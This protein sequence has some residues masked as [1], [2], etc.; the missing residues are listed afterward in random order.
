MSGCYSN[1]V[2]AGTEPAAVRAALGRTTAFMTDVIDGGIVVFPE[3]E[4]A[5][6]AIGQNLSKRLGCAC[7][8]M[9]VFEDGIFEYHLFVSGAPRDSYLSMSLSDYTGETPEGDPTLSL[10]GSPD[11]LVSA[12][13]GDP[14]IVGHVLDPGNDEFVFAQDRHQ[15]L[16][17]ALGL[18][19]LP[20]NCGYRD[21]DGDT[22]R[23][24]G[25]THVP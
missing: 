5:T 25:L 21:L 3:N 15:A 6:G 22:E 9:H 11:E 8:V 10:T 17:I 1:L 12:F 18:S 16:L 19:T 14:D 7:L 20:V 13:S 2:L 23:A 24:T 4:D